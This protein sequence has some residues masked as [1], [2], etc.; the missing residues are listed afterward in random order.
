MIKGIS[1]A[2]NVTIEDLALLNSFY[3]LSRFCTSILA[4]D[5]KGNLLHARNLDFGQ[6]F[7][8]WNAEIHEWRLTS[9]LKKVRNN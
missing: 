9:S 2:T 3:E 6:L 8:G 5:N 1:Q 7:G 4:K